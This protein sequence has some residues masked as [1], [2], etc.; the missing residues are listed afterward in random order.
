MLYN[1]I[2]TILRCQQLFHNFFIEYNSI[3]YRLVDCATTSIVY[4]NLKSQC[5]AF[6]QKIIRKFMVALTLQLS[7]LGIY[8]YLFIYN[9]NALKIYRLPAFRFNNSPPNESK[10]S[11]PLNTKHFLY[12]VRVEK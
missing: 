10:K 6:L 11:F 5:K 9:K 4:L 12:A 8:I 7:V 3:K 2:K 1:N